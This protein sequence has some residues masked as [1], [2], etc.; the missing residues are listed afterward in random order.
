MTNKNNEK[1]FNHHSPSLSWIH[2][3]LSISFITVV[4]DTLSLNSFIRME[5]NSKDQA[6]FAVFL[7][8]QGRPSSFSKSK[9]QIEFHR[10]LRIKQLLQLLESNSLETEGI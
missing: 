7:A 9:V 4:P 1:C 2:F 6:I 10:S 3:I 5:E 8:L